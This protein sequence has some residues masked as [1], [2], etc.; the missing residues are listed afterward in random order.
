MALGI[1]RL[2]LASGATTLAVC[3]ASAA[4][5]LN[6]P[7]P[8]AAPLRPPVGATPGAQTA[9]LVIPPSCGRVVLGGGQGV[10]TQLSAAAQQAMLQIQQAVG[11]RAAQRQILSR[12]SPADRQ[13]VT[14]SLS[15]N[16]AAAGK[17]AGSACAGGGPTSGDITASVGS[18]GGPVVPITNTYVS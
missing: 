5:V 6:D 9:G 2:K 7:K 1:G 13:A 18:G 4:L 17:G 8:A 11:N 15:Q 14:A 3:G 10:P 12:L 16:A